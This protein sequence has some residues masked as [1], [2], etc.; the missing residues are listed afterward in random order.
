L[1]KANK[2]L[3]TMKATRRRGK[4]KSR[5]NLI[6]FLEEINK[7]HMDKIHASQTFLHKEKFKSQSMKNYEL[8]VRLLFP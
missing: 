2:G 8:L 7:N 4:L 1:D 5:H 6:F 3:N